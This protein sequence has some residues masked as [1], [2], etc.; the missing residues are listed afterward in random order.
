MTAEPADAP[1]PGHV[2]GDAEDLPD[3][4]ELPPIPDALLAPLLDAAGDAL[5]RL[6]PADVPPAARRLRSFDRRG[7]A[8]PAARRQLRKILE[9]EHAVLAAAITLFRARPEVA[10]L[11]EAW[12]EAIG[13]GGDAPV[14]LVA[15]AAG[16][17]RLP[18][19]A[20][21]L[22]SGLP[23]CF[24]FGLGLVVAYSAIGGRE[25]ATTAAVRAATAAREA[26][27]E[28]RRRADAARGAAETEAA[29]LD[30]SL[31]EERQARRDREQEAADAAAGSE[32]R[33]EQMEAERD[34]ALARAEAEMAAADRRSAEAARRMAEADRRMDE[35]NRLAA[36]T[37]RRIEEAADR[38]AQAEERA[39]RA[40]ARAASA[41]ERARAAASTPSD[42]P[43]F[44]DR[45]VLDQIARAAEDLAAGV[46]R[47]ADSTAVPS[48]PSV[49]RRPRSTPPPSAA[50]PS[51][52]APSA[53]TRPAQTRP[54]PPL[55][56]SRNAGAPVSRRSARRAPVRLPPGM[57]QD[58]PA[59]IE[60]MVRTRNLAVIVDGYNV[61]MLAWPEASAAEQRERLCDALAEFQ[62]RFRCEVT[63]VF[64]GA[65]VPGV[66]PLRRRNLRVVFSAAG[67]EADEVVVGEVMFRPEDVPVI[68]VSSDR[69]VKA[70]A[71]AEGATVLSADA[72]LQ[73]MRR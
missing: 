22:T 50:P 28:A 10:E 21:V 32:A 15:A 59:A 54:A 47:L 29:R 23:D 46:R 68:V 60:A 16:D 36:E 49:A 65:E 69:E 26:A 52:A 53:P 8:T 66:R 1:V 40:E 30:R 9:E 25:A 38:A 62:L 45:T 61:T 34:A 18:L 12:N 2:A 43:R 19:L 67:Q 72:L 33:R 4:Q 3:E 73:L 71:E 37:N 58:D 39:R 6:P 13:A 57:L 35:V 41:E 14:E 56:Q 55:P 17:G 7:L 48:G 20:S 11:A 63:V 27:E 24:E 42:G 51:A 5:R 31:R 44:V 70:K 64:D